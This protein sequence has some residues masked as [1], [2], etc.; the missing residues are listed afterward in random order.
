MVLENYIPEKLVVGRKVLLDVK[1]SSKDG[2]I[3]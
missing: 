3:S 2:R 1:W